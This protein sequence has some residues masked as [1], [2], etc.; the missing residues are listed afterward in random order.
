MRLIEPSLPAV[1]YLV[2]NMR[3]ADRAEITAMGGAE[4]VDRLAMDVLQRWGAYAF[5]AMA[6]DY[7]AAIVGARE[8]WPGVW[9]V[10][11]FGTDEF[12]K[13]A[14]GLTK[15]IRR[16]MIPHLTELGAHRAQAISVDGHWRAHRWLEA[17]G[18]VQEARL[19]RYGR[20]GEDFLV[21]RWDRNVQS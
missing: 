2:Q 16:V 11:A 6:D 4:D 18:A 19:R 9:S 8:M 12:L 15:F 10:W 21:F 5:V 7:P 1:H 14:R 13:V 17:L 20:N 3:E